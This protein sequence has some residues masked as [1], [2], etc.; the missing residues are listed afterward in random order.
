[1][2]ESNLDTEKIAALLAGKLDEPDRS[3]ALERLAS[4]GDDFRLFIETAAVLRHIEEEEAAGG[5]P[6]RDEPEAVADPPSGNL[7][8]DAG[9]EADPPPA[10]DLPPRADPSCDADPPGLAD[11]PAAPVLSPP[12][13]AAPRWRRRRLWIASTLVGAA[14]VIALLMV[15]RRPAQPADLATPVALLSRRGLPP[16]TA[17]DH[18]WGHTLGTTP[19]LAPT[20]RAARAG[21]LHTELALALRARDAAGAARV[22]AQ[23]E[24]VLAGESLAAPTRDLY[25]RA[26]GAAASDPRRAAALLAQA[27]EGAAGVLDAEWMEA[28]A[29]AEAGRVAAADNDEAFFT[30]PAVRAELDRIGRLSGLGDSA[31]G[32]AE[33]LRAQVHAGPPFRWDVLEDGMKKLLAGLAS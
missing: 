9:S 24:A 3:A 30:A 25:R 23:L 17:D 14:A 16:D 7:E 11:P 6:A 12:P 21:A 26:A 29:W 22:V 13:S 1:M 20:V 18:R 27:G 32:A 8:A 19:A 15:L 31:R 2:K 33:G 10:A 28:G 4:S 5:P